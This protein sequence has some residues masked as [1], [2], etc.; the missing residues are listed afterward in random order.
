MHFIHLWQSSKNIERWNLSYSHWSRLMKLSAVSSQL[1]LCR[2]HPIPLG[3]WSRHPHY[4]KQ[5]HT[6]IMYILSL[7]WRIPLLMMIFMYLRVLQLTRI[8]DSHAV[9]L[10][11][12]WLRNDERLWTIRNEP[13]IAKYCCITNNI[14][15]TYSNVWNFNIRSPQ[16]RAI[17]GSVQACIISIA[18]APEILQYFGLNP[19]PMVGRIN[20]AAIC[21]KQ[22]H[23]MGH[24]ALVE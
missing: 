4:I 13:C 2:L 15:D 7:L 3:S 17:D 22:K 1:G 24:V 11:Q 8:V 12:P 6:R 9:S 16:P 21:L 10:V 14:F 20:M 23:G 18:N 5:H 19:A